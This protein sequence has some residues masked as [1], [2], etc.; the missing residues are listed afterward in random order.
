MA[1]SGAAVDPGWYPDA[2]A[3]GVLRWFDG[4]RWTEHTR[5]AAPGPHHD[6]APYG[7]EPQ[8]P[9][10]WVVPVGRR[11]WAIVAGYVAIFAAFCWLLAPIALG[12]GI[13]AL[14]DINRHGGLG[15]GRAWFAIATGGVGTL[16]LLLI[17]AASIV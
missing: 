13:W 11:G 7:A 10:H 14:V 3:T 12:M 5:S 6:A 16:L 9:L 2:Y 1:H 8:D 4:E 17:V 15:Q